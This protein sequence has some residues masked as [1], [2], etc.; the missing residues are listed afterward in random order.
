MQQTN[1]QQPDRAF[2]AGRA[3]DYLKQLVAI[4]SP[5]GDEAAIARH[6]GGLLE[7]L[8]LSVTLQ[9][10][11]SRFNVIARTPATRDEADIL[12]TGH[13]D[14]IPVSQG[15][16]TD[17]FK[18]VI[19]GDRMYGLGACDQKGGIAAMIA[20][21]EGLRAAGRLDGANILVAFVPDEEALS[22]GMLAFLE[23]KPKARLALLSEPHFKE[24]TIGWPGKALVNIVVHG[25]SAH[26]GSRPWEGIN[27]I[28]EAARLLVALGR[29]EPP[30]HERL[31]SHSFVTLK[32]RGG[33]ERYSLTVPDRCEITI[34]KQLV[35][36]ESKETVARLV[37]Q[38]ASAMERARAEVSFDRP[39]Y[40]PAAQ[41]PSHPQVQRFSRLYRKVTG[42]ELLLGYGEGVLD[43]NYS[44][45]AGIPTISWGP[46]GANL[47]RADE[48]V[49][50]DELATA[51]EVYFR[52]CLE[53]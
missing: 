10:V 21:L 23:T 17:P 13:M 43:G 34:S 29:V 26:G 25:K 7:S 46:S 30:R 49:S 19:A 41:D 45:D 11:G 1:M 3:L 8:G 33:Y 5:S 27:A 36:G 38:A 40:P 12:L 53:G 50:L 2:L 35:P 20:A 9:P 47:H 31:G 16:S 48:W 44:A 51:A 4:P 52:M 37:E 18:P 24:A 6:I 14:T 39:Y 15:W 28:E 42:K 22:D 32:V